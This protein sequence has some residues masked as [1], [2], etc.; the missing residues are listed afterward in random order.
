M[1]P[2]TAIVQIAKKI[3]R[4]LNSGAEASEDALA[5]YWRRRASRLQLSGSC[6][7]RRSAI[8]RTIA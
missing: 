3:G 1:I 5:R 2:R 8:T 4:E 6:L 7:L